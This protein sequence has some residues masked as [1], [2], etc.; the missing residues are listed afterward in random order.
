MLLCKHAEQGVPLQAEEY[1]WLADTDEEIDEQEL[2][3]HYSY[4][5]KFR[6]NTYLV[7]TDDSNVI[8]NSPDMCDDDIQNDQNDVESDD[9]RVT[10]ANLIA[11]LKLD[12][13][14]NKKIQKQLKKAN[15]T[16]AQDLKECKTILAETS[17]A[18]GESIS[19]WDSCLVA[20]QNK[21]TEFEKY[22]PLM[23]VPMTMTNLNQEMHADLE[24]VESLEKE[25]DEL[26]YDKAEFSNMY[27]MIL[28][29][30]VFKDVMCSYL[31]SLSDLDAL[32]ELQ[33]LY[34]HKVKECDCLTQ[35]LSNQI[36]SVSKKVHIELLQLFAK[37]EKH[38]ISLEI[39]LQKCKEQLKHD[40]FWNEKASNVFREEHEQYF[41][42][43]YLK[44]QLQ[45]RNIAIN[46]EVA[47]QKSTCFVRDLQGNDLLTGIEH[48]TSTARTTKQNG[49][50]KRQN[51]TLVEAAR[52]ML[53]ALKLPL[54]FWAEAIATACYTQNQSTIIP[55]YDKTAY[56]IINDRKP[57]IKNLYIFGCIYYITKD[58]ENLDKMKEKGDLCIL[59]G[60]ST[61]LKG[62]RVY[63]KRTRMI[64][65]SI[66]IR[67]DE[68]KEVS[69]TSVANDTSGLIP[70]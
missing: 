30:C 11:N 25:I 46:L 62:Y 7:E 8:P 41:K 15:T 48:Q 54:F 56:H 5:A 70:Q 58:G 51:R 9:E 37:V 64:V 35:K 23:T 47:F 32:D 28:Q 53:L 24:Y 67:F 34:L 68:I 65:E 18:L 12:V 39:A 45:D 44:A 57:L 17:N 31:L 22:R 38:L 50:V 26:E 6:S 43:Q 14:E 42:I 19:I 33:C 40:T 63:N 1:D 2:E 27:D 21:Q 52:T 59:V 69:E 60:Y 61:Q 3:A 55:T 49:V 20:L 4:M 10:L 66:H 13:D 29:E 16:L 36:E